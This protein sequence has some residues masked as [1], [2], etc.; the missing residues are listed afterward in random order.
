MESMVIDAAPARL[1]GLAFS[2]LYLCFDIG[3]GVGSMGGGLVASFTGYGT[4][5]GLVGVLCLLTAG[6]F[7]L[8]TRKFG[9]GKEQA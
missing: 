1:R 6:L 8:A 7:A 3:I 5:Y 9:S 4:I 2:F